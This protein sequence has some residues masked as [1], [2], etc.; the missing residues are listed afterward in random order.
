LD[1]KLIFSEPVLLQAENG[2]VQGFL[3]IYGDHIIFDSLADDPLVRVRGKKFYDF[4]VPLADVSDAKHLLVR[5]VSPAFLRITIKRETGILIKIEEAKEFDFAMNT[6]KVQVIL[7]II[8]DYEC[9]HDG[10]NL[11]PAR[12]G[13]SMRDI[14]DLIRIK[15]R[16]E[17]SLNHRTNSQPIVRRLSVANALNSVS[18]DEKDKE[19]EIETTSLSPPNSYSASP[20]HLH[21]NHQHLHHHASAPN[22]LAPGTSLIGSSGSSSDPN[23]GHD[24][25][26]GVFVTTSS[27]MNSLASHKSDKSDDSNED[28]TMNNVQLSNTKEDDDQE[29][30][31]EAVAHRMLEDERPTTFEDPFLPVLDHQSHFLKPEHVEMLHEKV[32]PRLGLSNWTLVYS[33]FVHGISLNTMY[34]KMQQYQGPSLII[35]EDQDGY[36]RN[37]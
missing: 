4:E 8:A 14:K 10:Q 16:K 25:A 22:A 2:N 19:D 31:E 34:Y 7:A 28:Q 9:E 15:K 26:I 33:T 18:E 6:E 20:E 21:I 24:A 27:S 30:S 3:Q 37:L 32:P 17:E 1:D 35:I 5:Q 12:K 29:E 36:V 11:K 23:A 13:V